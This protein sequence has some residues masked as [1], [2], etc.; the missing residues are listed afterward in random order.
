MTV[1]FRVW[2]IIYE[3]G[4]A[5]FLHAVFSTISHHLEPDGWGTKYPELM[6][7]LFQGKMSH[8][9]AEKAIQD[10]IEIR[11]ALMKY[12]HEDIVWDV[13]GIEKRPS[14][15]INIVTSH[16]NL[17]DCLWTKTGNRKVL[18][19]MLQSFEYLKKKGGDITIEQVFI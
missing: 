8:E 15:C 16:K 19:V 14:E 18:D 11:E 17:P 1:G 6:N 3:I 10:I 13:Y 5:D 12:T 9:H 7:D 2:R 4:T